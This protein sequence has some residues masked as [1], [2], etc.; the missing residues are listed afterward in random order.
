M[1]KNKHYIDK[2]HRNAGKNLQENAGEES[3]KGSE[4]ALQCGSD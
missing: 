2:R 1:L 4:T 3:E